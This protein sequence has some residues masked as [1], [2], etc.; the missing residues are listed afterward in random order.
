MQKRPIHSSQRQC[1]YKKRR[2]DTAQIRALLA[3][4]T[5]REA[6]ARKGDRAQPVR[7]VPVIAAGRRAFLSPASPHA[8]AARAAA[9]VAF[10]MGGSLRAWHW[11]SE[12][13]LA[14][15]APPGHENRSSQRVEMRHL[16]CATPA[17]AGGRA[18]IWPSEH[19]SGHPGQELPTIRRSLSDP[20]LRVRDGRKRLVTTW[21]KRNQRQW[22]RWQM[23]V[24]ASPKWSI[25]AL[26]GDS[27]L[28][29]STLGS[30]RQRL[31]SDTSL[32]NA[33][34][35]TGAARASVK[36]TPRKTAEASQ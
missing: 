20:S 14:Q 17:S 16:R 30:L 11:S 21:R 22:S 7:S 35:E 13:E 12:G 33:G 36:W 5:R 15:R 9:T 31:G 28:S 29:S 18:G 3:G 4:V 34:S 26:T 25:T 19:R 24:A 27:G 23:A 8:A 1:V 6:I 2:S 10:R 32:P